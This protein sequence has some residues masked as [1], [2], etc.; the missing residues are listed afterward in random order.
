MN[1]KFCFKLDIC[2]TEAYKIIKSAYGCNV[3]NRSQIF[4]WFLI[5]TAERILIKDEQRTSRSCSSSNDENVD[6]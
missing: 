3:M 4:G 6:H 5:V 1:I 2:A